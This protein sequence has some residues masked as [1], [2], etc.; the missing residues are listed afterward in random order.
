MHP[1][2]DAISESFERDQLAGR[3]VQENLLP[4]S[5]IQLGELR[6]DYRIFPSLV[7]SGDSVEYVELADG[8]VLFYIADVSG[9]GAAGALVSALVK[10]INFGLL[11]DIE[12]RKLQNPAE[13]LEAFNRAIRKFDIEQHVT[14]FL[15]LLDPKNKLL[16]FSNAAHFPATIFITGQTL[17]YLELG[18]LPLGMYQT[19]GYVSKEIN[20]PDEYS[21][22]MFSDGVLEIMAQATIQDKEEHLKMLVKSG[23]RD[24]DSLV[25]ELGID[26]ALNAPDDIA[27]FT[28]TSSRR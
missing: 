9:H 26:G 7:L 5:G 21:I 22:V 17:D 1:A 6:F 2:E 15:G 8:R 11:P 19:P 24:V 3:R 14:M 28:I 10:G 23:M 18:S 13:V 12:E 25:N 16:H 20:L 4:R 27:L